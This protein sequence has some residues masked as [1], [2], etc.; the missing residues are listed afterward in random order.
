M[1]SQ[2]NHLKNELRIRFQTGLAKLENNM[3]REVALKELRVLI[4][5]NISPEA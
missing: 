4:E 3:T 5:R 1:A 2:E